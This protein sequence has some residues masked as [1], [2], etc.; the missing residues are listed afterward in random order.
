[1]PTADEKR[2]RED[3]ENQVWS[4]I[5]AFEQIVETMP[6]DRVSLE[7][8][9]SAY[10]Q[11]G[12][13]TRARE[14]LIRLVNVIIQEN[15]HNA[16]GLLHERL[17][18]YAADD[19]VARETEARLDAMLTSGKPAPREFDLAATQAEPQDQQ[20]EEA[21]RR[22]AHVAA[23]LSF[24]WTL[25]EAKELTQEDY[26]QVAQDLS[27]VSA[28]KTVVTVSVL[29]VLHDRTN[30]NLERVMAFAS[31][32]S[33]LPIIP[34]SLFDV[35][36]AAFS[37]LPDEFVVRY[38]AMVFELMGNDALV[39]ILNPYNEALRKWVSRAV[40]KTCHFYLTT[41]ADF[42]AVLEKRKAAAAATATP[43]APAEGAAP[44]APT[45]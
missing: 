21:E 38:G 2:Q 29:H 22:S 24:A 20:L 42:D 11:V 45:P 44:A 8:L 23:E 15:D 43:A 19:S 17:L 32:G 37:L 39:A 28:G 40:K 41:P 12:D 10:E 7:A 3:L 36:D 14:Y 30:R 6:N 16:G 5:A 9:S 13:L 25:F 35:Q 26:A 4:A 34:V 31:K 27:E 18:R 1:M 33:G